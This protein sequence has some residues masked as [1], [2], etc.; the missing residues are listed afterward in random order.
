[1]VTSGV[2]AVELDSSAIRAPVSLAKVFRAVHLGNLLKKTTV[3]A[4]AV[5]AAHRT[6]PELVVAV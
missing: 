5:L 4:A 1:M 2:P 3:A 6:F